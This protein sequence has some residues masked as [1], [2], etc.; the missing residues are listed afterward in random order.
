MVELD[1]Y[2]NV[3][4]V[5]WQLDS[6]VETVDVSDDWKGIISVFDFKRFFS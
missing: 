1:K 6:F 2:A 3:Y 5:F 4:C